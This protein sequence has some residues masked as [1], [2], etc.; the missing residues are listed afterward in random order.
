MRKVKAF[1]IKHNRKIPGAIIFGCLFLILVIGA[2][3]LAKDKTQTQKI[4]DLAQEIKIQNN[5]LREQNEQL[6]RQNNQ[7]KAQAETNERIAKEGRNFI[8]CMFSLWA[9]YTRDA[10]PVTIENYNQCI[11]SYQLPLLTA[12]PASPSTKKPPQNT[13]RQGATPS[14]GNQTRQ[15]NPPP[16]PPESILPIINEPVIGCIMDICI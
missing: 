9:K 7:L 1:L 8:K 4:V 6:E 12:P 13:S 10:I 3:T 15:N 11:A 5:Y 16:K 14:S 2:A